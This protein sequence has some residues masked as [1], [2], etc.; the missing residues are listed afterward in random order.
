MEAGDGWV[1][2]DEPSP[3]REHVSVATGWYCVG[4]LINSYYQQGLSQINLH[5][6]E[7][8][9]RS[10]CNHRHTRVPTLSTCWHRA[11]QFLILLWEYII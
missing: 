6:A 7:G 11:C 2:L 10:Q 3:I 9:K 8:H 1:V 4:M 5:M